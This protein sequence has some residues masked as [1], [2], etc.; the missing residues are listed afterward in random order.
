MT[1]TVYIPKPGSFLSKTVLD[2]SAI[3]GSP[4]AGGRVRIDYEGGKFGQ[5]GSWREMLDHAAG[6]HVTNYPTI[7]RMWVDPADVLEVG[8][9]DYDTRVLD[10]TDAEALDQ[11]SPTH[12]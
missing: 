12:A 2:G 8:T 9:F 4:A 5:F 7:A 3:V 10:I 6:R 1:L 11:W